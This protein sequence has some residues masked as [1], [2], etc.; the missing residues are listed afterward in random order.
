MSWVGRFHQPAHPSSGL[1]GQLAIVL[2]LPTLLLESRKSIGPRCFYFAVAHSWPCWLS[3]VC[4]GA[5]IRRRPARCRID[6]R[7][8]WAG[9][10][11]RQDRAGEPPRRARLLP[12]WGNPEPSRL[13]T[14]PA[15]AERIER[16]LELCSAA[17]DAAVSIGP[18]R[19]RGD[20]ITTSATLAHWRPLALIST[21][22]MT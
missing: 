2:S 12:G 15:T 16:L 21:W 3:W 20:R 6:R 17:R 5:R 8:A 7:P 9:L 19:P 10:G 11:A 13:R 22:G 18:F 4:P 1:V 14:H